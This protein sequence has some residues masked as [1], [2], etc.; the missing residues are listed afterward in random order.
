ML[1]DWDQLA[2]REGERER[3]E[4]HTP[5]TDTYTHKKTDGKDRKHRDKENTRNIREKK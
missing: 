1:A 3:E 5:G 4:H 2:E